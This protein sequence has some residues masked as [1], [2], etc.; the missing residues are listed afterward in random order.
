MKH[1]RNQR[2]HSLGLSVLICAAGS[3]R[4]IAGVCAVSDGSM[5][6]SEE[7]CMLAFVFNQ[8]GDHRLVVINEKTRHRYEAPLENAR[9]A[10]FWDGGKV[11]VVGVSGI[12][13]GFS[14]ASDKLVPDKAETI[15]REVVRTTEYSRG[16][17][18]LYLI[19]THLDEQRNVLYELSSIDFPARKTLWIKRIDG[20]GTLMIMDGYICVA[21]LKLVQVYNC[22]TGEKISAVQAPKEASTANA[23]PHKLN[24]SI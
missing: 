10:P 11:F 19:R 15:S 8:E 6:P 22:D 18:R 4:A 13:Q 23:N 9:M 14:I 16:R 12:I 1:F 2:I 24:E 7:G 3:V 21:G 20:P 17:H 5:L